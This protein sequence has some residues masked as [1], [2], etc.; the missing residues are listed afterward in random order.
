MKT[1]IVRLLDSGCAL[2][3]HRFGCR[4]AYWS[5]RLDERWDTGEWGP[6]RSV[7]IER[8]RT[9]LADCQRTIRALDDLVQD[10]RMYA[11]QDACKI[12]Q[13]QALVAEL[14][15][16]AHGDAKSGASV[17]HWPG[18]HDCEP[19]CEDCQWHLDSVALLAR[20]EAGEFGPLNNS[21]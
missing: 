7:K 21:W 14:L 9:E 12:E 16:F 18:G 20:I 13:L 11:E 15:P 5:E 6:F 17:A 3:G 4:L 8:V 10:L 2:T 19:I 1:Q